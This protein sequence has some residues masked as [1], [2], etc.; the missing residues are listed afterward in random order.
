M[1]TEITSRPAIWRLLTP[2]AAS[3]AISRSRGVSSAASGVASSVGGRAPSHCSQP[4]AR[5]RAAARARARRRRPAARC[6]RGGGV[7]RLGGHEQ[8]V[9]A[10]RSARPTSSSAGAVA[11][12]RA[13][14]ACAGGDR[15]RTAP[16]TRAAR[17]ASSG[18]AARGVAEPAQLVQRAHDVRVLAA[19]TRARSAASAR[20]APAPRE[21]SP[22]AAALHGTRELQL[23][24]EG[25]VAERRALHLRDAPRGPVSGS[26]ALRRGLGDARERE[27]QHARP[28]SPSRMQRGALAA[29]PQRGADAGRAPARCT[30]SDVRLDRRC[31]PPTG[32]RSAGV[33]A[34]RGRGRV[35]QPPRDA[36]RDSPH[37]RA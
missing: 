6:A 1:R 22:S 18:A 10:R 27:G 2:P 33:G 34:L 23:D 25:L 36:E 30:P 17:R 9:Q 3:S 8:R 13:P 24:L 15:P 21:S 35:G 12:H 29:E 28:L 4:D 14:A 20:R 11:G 5:T 31:R 37:P 32:A 7:G 19:L 16:S 26:P